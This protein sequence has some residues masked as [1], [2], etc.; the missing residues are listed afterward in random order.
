MEGSCEDDIERFREKCDILQEEWAEK[1]ERMGFM[2]K[3]AKQ[4]IY[5]FLADCSSLLTE[6]K[7]YAEEHAV[8]RDFKQVFV[9]L[10]QLYDAIDGSVY[11]S[12]QY[13]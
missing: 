12:E 4:V 6:M 8:D 10:F 1:A 2:D 7:N 13:V 9:D 5:P 3:P 11:N